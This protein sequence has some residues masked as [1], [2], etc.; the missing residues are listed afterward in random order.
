MIK[1]VIFTIQSFLLFFTNHSIGQTFDYFPASTTN[2][3]IKHSY[4][5]LSYSSANRQAEWVA[6]V[7]SK[8]NVLNGSEERTDDFR[9]DPLVKSGSAS[10]DDYKGSGYDRGHLAPAGDMKINSTAMSESFYLS[11]MSP[12]TPSFN[13][14]IWKKLEEQV[15]GWASEY[16]SLYIMTGGI[17]K[18]SLGTIGSNNVTIPKYFYK[19]IFNN[20]KTDK[21]VIAFILPNEKGTKQL[22]EY[23]VT[24]DSVESITGIDFFPA[25]PDSTENPLESKI[26][27]NKWTFDITIDS[28]TTSN[29]KSVQCKGITK[30]GDRCKNKTLNENGYCYIHKSQATSVNQNTTTPSTTIKRTTS[31]QCSATTKAG[32]L[33]KHMT[34]SPNGKC[35]QHGGD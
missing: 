11:N 3:I 4:Y 33:C 27:I 20:T 15:R 6:Y 2:Q 5:S 13:R 14:G 31:V 12:Q 32:T 7:L 17:L 35:W 21:K 1:T 18:F 26:E 22:Y 10:L 29:S 16:D 30:D 9:V 23:A 8:Y 24:I 19:I 34:Y 25:L 28:L